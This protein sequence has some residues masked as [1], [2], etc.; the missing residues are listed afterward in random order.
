[1]GQAFAVDMNANNGNQS[2]ITKLARI[3]P[4][5]E[6]EELID[7]NEY[8]VGVGDEFLVELQVEK[9]SIVV[10]VVASGELLIPGA[11]TFLLSGKTLSESLALIK[12]NLSNYAK[13]S[14]FDVKNI[15]I[16][17][18]GAV[19]KPGIYSVKGNWRLS[20]VIKSVPLKYLSKDFE[21]N[22]ID[23]QDTSVVNIYDFYL[24]G[25]KKSNPYLH[26]GETIYIPFADPVS[27]CVEVY[28][29]VMARSFIPFIQGETLGEFY[30]RKVVM[31]DV[32]NYE[33]IMVVR[34]GKQILVS[35]AEMDAFVLHAKDKIEFIALKQIMVSGHVNRPGTYDFVPGHTVIDYI[36]MAGGTNYKGSNGSAIV[37]RDSKKIKNP[38]DMQIHR[39]D[40]ILVKRSAEDILIGEISILSF[41]SLIATIASTVITAFIAAGNI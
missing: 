14:F 6:M 40:I 25:D 29:P 30:R 17:V 38:K 12:S 10:P 28:G 22:I 37:I 7:P 36:S 20:D 32:M 4:P 27:E 11:G 21:I 13:V 15:R 33:K 41:V 19:L 23:G 39:G 31:S 24:K 16:P 1:V 2:K 9:T 8:I 18:V 35:D 5:S 26:A 34:Q 3:T